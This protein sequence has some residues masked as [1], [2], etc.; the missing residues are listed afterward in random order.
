MGAPIKNITPADEASAEALLTSLR[1]ID[2]A[3][4]RKHALVFNYWLSIRGKRQFPAIRDLDPLEISDAGPFSLLMEMI[5]GGEDAEIRHF[6]HAIKQ[7]VEAHRISDAQSPSLL[8]C[9]H[10]SCRWSRQT[11]A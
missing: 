3:E 5:G 2:P 11:A 8:N 4:R 10:A 9:I 7:G 6:G 1:T